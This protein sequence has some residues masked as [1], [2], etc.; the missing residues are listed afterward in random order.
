M[1]PFPLVALARFAAVALTPSVRAD[2]D[3][4]LGLGMNF[5]TT[6]NGIT[7]PTPGTLNY[8]SRDA[9]VSMR[10]ESAKGPPRR[11]RCP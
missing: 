4:G 7:E 1:M 3:Y 9:G 10:Q 5:A 6:A 2:T 8:T 11:W